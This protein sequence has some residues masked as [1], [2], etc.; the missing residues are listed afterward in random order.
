M[1]TREQIE[2]DTNHY[3]SAGGRITRLKQGD[4]GI[5]YSSPVHA[6]KTAKQAKGGSKSRKPRA[7]R[8][9]IWLSSISPDI[10]KI[11]KRTEIYI[12]HE[13]MAATLNLLGHKSYTDKP[14]TYHTIKYAVKTIGVV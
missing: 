7:F 13:R 11:M 1:L 8:Q 3:L 6:M 14:L 9:S 5:D 10:K 4:T 2:R 12:G